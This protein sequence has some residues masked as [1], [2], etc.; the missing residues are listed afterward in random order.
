MSRRSGDVVVDHI[1][2]HFGRG[3]PRP[4]SPWWWPLNDGAELGDW[5]L[6]PDDLRERDLSERSVLVNLR[7]PTARRHQ[8]LGP[9]LR[10]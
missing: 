4:L 1:L 3:L 10:R 9:L 7:G 2:R 8:R 6:T 5:G